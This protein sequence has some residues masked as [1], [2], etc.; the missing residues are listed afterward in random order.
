MPGQEG[1]TYTP[2]EPTQETAS[3]GNALEQ[4]VG[5]EGGQRGGPDAPAKPGYVEPRE[6]D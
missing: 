2:V 1:P 5:Y 4:G 3:G 6:G